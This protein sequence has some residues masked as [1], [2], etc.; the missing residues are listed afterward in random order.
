MKKEFVPY[1]LALRMKA[2]GFNEPSPTLYTA[3]GSLYRS[4]DLNG[5]TID[6]IYPNECLAPTLEQSFD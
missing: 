1:S 4:I 3:K 6:K 2:L 5:Y